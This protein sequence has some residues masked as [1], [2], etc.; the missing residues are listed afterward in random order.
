MGVENYVE[1]YGRVV[2]D[3]L[4]TMLTETVITYFRT[5]NKHILQALTKALQ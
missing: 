4:A 5:D 2:V 1:I 3:G